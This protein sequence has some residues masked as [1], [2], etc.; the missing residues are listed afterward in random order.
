MSDGGRDRSSLGV[1]VW[2]SSQKWSAQRSAV[3]SI[4]WLGLRRNNIKS[5]LHQ[6]SRVV[7]YSEG[8]ASGNDIPSRV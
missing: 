3:G 1:K 4:A 5:F 2:K 7:N 8:P 6:H